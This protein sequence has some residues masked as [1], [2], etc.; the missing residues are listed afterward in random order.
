[1]E[2]KPLSLHEQVASRLIEMLKLGTSPWMK[3][4]NSDGA[5]VFQFPY[6]A[7]TGNRYR[8]IN[9]LHLLMSGREDP[10]WLT[11][12]Q[13]ESMQAKVN[14]GEKGT[15]IQFVKTHQQKTLRD[16]KGRV[17]FDELGNAVVERLTLARPLVSNAWV[18]NAAQISGLDPLES[19]SQKPLTWDP[20]LRAEE[21]IGASG[22]EI[23]HRY[24]DSAYYDMRYDS[25]T[26]PQRNQFDSAALYYATALH[27]L[28]HW[29]GHPSRLNRA[30][31]IN[32]GIKEYSKEELRAEIASMI[33]GSELGIGHNPSQHASYV[34]SWV[35]ILEDTPFEIH[36]AAADAE[37]IADFLLSMERKISLQ[38]DQQ[39]APP[40]LKAG[41]GYLLLG[42]EIA[43]KDSIYRVDAHLKQGRL[44]MQQH[45]SG[46]QFILSSADPLYA[47]LLQQKEMQVSRQLISGSNGLELNPHSP[48]N[49]IKRSL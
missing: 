22:A 43:Y 44:K 47:S 6:N 21:L 26:L 5:G 33:I 45:P 30:S 19:L 37:K 3:P 32:S 1:M 15:L 13:A 35:S 4:W 36:A 40:S 9:A 49:S 28:A 39:M 11:F 27:E 38:T 46:L 12:K 24:I 18:F 34:E 48:T 41:Q 7:Q 8:G 20:V 2:T 10:R 25:I 42:D 16:E 31:L 23:N 29:S 14:K 17:V